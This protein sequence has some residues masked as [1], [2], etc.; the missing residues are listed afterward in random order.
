MLNRRLWRAAWAAIFLVAWG[1]AAWADCSTRHFYNNDSVPFLLIMH[2]GACTVA[3]STSM[4]GACVIPPGG[5]AEIHYENVSLRNDLLYALSSAAGGGRES[6]G[7]GFKK[8]GG[9][10]GSGTM[11]IVSYDNGVASPAQSFDVKIDDHGCYIKHHDDTGVLVMND[12]ANGDVQAACRGQCV[13][14]NA[15]ALQARITAQI[16]RSPPRRGN[17]LQYCA[18]S[19]MEGD[20]F[21]ADCRTLTGQIVTASLHHAGIC[22]GDVD[23]VDGHLVCVDVQPCAHYDISDEVV[24]NCPKWKLFTD[25]SHC[26][27]VYIDPR[28]PDRLICGTLP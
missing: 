12:P 4:Q 1:G 27:V 28:T 18:N 26:E 15:R 25:V 3:T 2:K 24:A 13:I 17:F 21:R 5:I 6:V 22:R 8:W 23:D 19:H 16:Q 7:Q 14:D 11:T 9:P 20:V 10:T